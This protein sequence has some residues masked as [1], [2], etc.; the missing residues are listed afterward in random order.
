MT[1]DDFGHDLERFWGATLR[2][3][4]FGS[5][6]FCQTMLYVRG[7]KS[8]WSFRTNNSSYKA[9]SEAFAACFLLKSFS[10]ISISK[11]IIA[12]ARC[13]GADANYIRSSFA[14]C[15]LGGLGTRGSL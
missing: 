6:H 11:G 5:V 15:I 4:P 13:S 1:K 8:G 12:P 7:V 14:H 2:E 9:C 10:S 3:K